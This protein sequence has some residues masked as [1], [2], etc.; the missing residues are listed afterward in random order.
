MFVEHKEQGEVTEAPAKTM[1]F[2]E[3]V[4]IG[5]KLRPQ[6][7][8]WSSVE[9]CVLMAA[10]EGHYGHMPKNWTVVNRFLDEV[11]KIPDDISGEAMQRNDNDRWTRERIA[12]WLESQGF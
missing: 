5:A 8:D 12:D 1:K 3:A 4:R 6:A 2:S 10:Y 11:Y 7:F 9:S